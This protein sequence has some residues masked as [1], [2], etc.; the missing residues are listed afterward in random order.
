M[1]N[2][3]AQLDNTRVSG[4]G[5]KGPKTLG[6]LTWV[7]GANPLAMV[8]KCGYSSTIKSVAAEVYFTAGIVRSE[9]KLFKLR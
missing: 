6:G 4:Y 1:Y 2:G 7:S 5:Q 8:G 3:L 9:V